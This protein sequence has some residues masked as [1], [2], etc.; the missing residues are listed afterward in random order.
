MLNRLSE[1]LV[2]EFDVSEET[3][4]ETRKLCLEQNAILS[5]MLVKKKVV[6][7]HQLLDAFSRLYRIPFMPKIAI[8]ELDTDFTRKVSIQFLKKFGMVPVRSHLPSGAAGRPGRSVYGP[9]AACDCHQRSV[10]VSS[11]G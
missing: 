5:E 7:E 3:F 2:Q 4:D 8:E 9:R 10:P 1:I 11:P 6:T